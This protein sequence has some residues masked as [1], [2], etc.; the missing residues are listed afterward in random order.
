MLLHDKR[1]H[2]YLYEHTLK[3]AIHYWS[4]QLLLAGTGIKMVRPWS[5]IG[6]WRHRLKAPS[7]SKCLRKKQQPYGRPES[8]IVLP[9]CQP[10]TSRGAHVQLCRGSEE[11][12]QGG[13]ATFT[14]EPAAWSRSSA[15]LR[16]PR[17]WCLDGWCP[18]LTLC[19]LAWI[20]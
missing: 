18:N 13:L 19:P 9:S 17:T 1:I 4:P 3:E 20:P 11:H 10:G 12:G 8:P 7:R 14:R 15:L 6:H 16:A 2:L 5:S